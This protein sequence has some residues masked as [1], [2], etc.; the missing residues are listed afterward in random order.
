[1]L[2]LCAGM[3]E[4]VKYLNIIVLGLTTVL[5]AAVLL[6]RA[7]TAQVNTEKI[8]SGAPDPGFH[9][10]F[11]GTALVKTGNVQLVQ[12]GFGARLEY[13]HERHQVYVQGDY[14]FAQKG[15][16]DVSDDSLRYLHS[17]F[18]HLR[19]TAMWHQ[20]MGLEVF[21]QVQFNE[22]TRLQLRALGGAGGRFVLLTGDSVEL[23][24]GS[25]YMAEYE[26]LDL[27][28][29]AVHPA[30]LVNHRWTNY[31]TLRVAIQEYLRLIATT[32]YQP[33]FDAFGDFRVLFDGTIE[34]DVID[35]L[36]F[37]VSVQVLHDSRP[38]DDIE[39]T[40]ITI[41]PAVKVTW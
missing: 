24:F 13:N 27:P 25:G 3:E 11:Q 20:H 36:A 28:D 15:G 5:L 9:G 38:P 17:G 35:H 6:P 37:V 32:Y 4:E 21:G 23:V 10:F 41:A 33:R 18:G 29:T 26:K 34:V 1:M 31:L 30:R 8:R 16:L 22:F 14:S 7:A 19:W 12:L 2:F 40:D 39:T